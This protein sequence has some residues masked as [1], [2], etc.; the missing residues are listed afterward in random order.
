MGTQGMYS[1]LPDLDP[2]AIKVQLAFYIQL[3]LAVA[4][5]YTK[6]PHPRHSYWDMWGLP[7]FNRQEVL[8]VYD[9]LVRACQHNVDAFVKVCIFDNRRGVES[10]VASFIVQ[11]PDE[12]PVFALQRQEVEGRKI[13]YTINQLR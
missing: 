7:M 2:A 4:I 11:R 1:F 5:E 8:P 12:E 10:C 3:G 9:E 13:H 6:E